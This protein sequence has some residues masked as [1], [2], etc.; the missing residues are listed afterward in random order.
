[1]YVVTNC[2]LPST[3][4]R[5]LL[6]FTLAYVMVTAFLLSPVL[7]QPTTLDSLHA[8]LNRAT[9]EVLKTRIYGNIGAY[10]VESNRDSA[11]YYMEV[12]IALSRKLNWKLAEATYLDYKAYTL[13]LMDNFPKSLETSLQA[14]KIAEDPASEKNDRSKSANPVSFRRQRI[15]A[16]IYHNIGLLYGATG[17]QNLQISNFKKAIQI[18]TANKDFLKV[19]E[20]NIFLGEVY[21]S[22]GKADSAL[23]MEKYALKTVADSG[24]APVKK[25]EGVIHWNLGKIYQLQSKPALAK[26]EYFIAIQKNQA[27]YNLSNLG[28]CFLSLAQL[29]SN[30]NNPD[31]ALYFARKGL[32]TYQSTTSSA[33]GIASAYSLLSSLYDQQKITDSALHFLQLASALK[34]SLGT[35]E[36]LHLAAFQDVGFNEQLRLAALEKERIQTQSR[37]KVYSLLA[38]LGVFSLLAIILYRNN[39]EKQRSNKVLENTLTNLRVTQ[40]QLVQSEKMASLGELTAGIAHEIQN[41]LNFV[42]NFSE[43]SQELLLEMKG[44]MQKGN[45]AEAQELADDVIQNLQKINHHG[46]RADAIVKSMLQHSQASTGRLEL[47]DINALCDECIRMTY[48]VLRGKDPDFNVAM[49]KDFD[50]SIGKI[51]IVP[52]DIS[53]V[54]VNLLS[55]AFYAV[56]EKSQAPPQGELP[57]AGYSPIVSLSSIKTSHGIL[58]KVEDNGTGIPANVVEKIFQPFFTT[59][60]SGQ[61]TGLGLS[62]SYD[63]ISKGHNGKL[64]VE[65]NIGQGSC[66]T[67]ELPDKETI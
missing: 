30:G 1:M 62:L 60:P 36:K 6:K 22:L 45:G 66:F 47:T 39:K 67:I 32:Y 28:D 63:I 44:E 8:A 52:S 61:G 19:A 18:S 59:K 4:C 10:H 13:M 57:E 17:N 58:I 40:D 50:E 56:K 11:L 23:V 16:N 54:L 2:L 34:D 12:D 33:R 21:I 41:P 65:T 51:N 20:V 7:A 55:N 49:E 27:N 29:Y 15:L 53:R 35:A 5:I 24:G 25:Y 38:G 3:L 9:D 46:K 43:V 37:I 48:H 42:N 14:L 64:K 31:S 26:Q